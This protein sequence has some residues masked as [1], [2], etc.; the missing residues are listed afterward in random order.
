MDTSTTLRD[1]KLIEEYAGKIMLLA[2]DT[3]TVRFRFFDTALMKLKLQSVPGLR[4][5]VCDGEALSYDPLKL[6]TDYKEEPNI[7]VRLY[8][9][10]MLHAIFMHPYDTTRPTRTSG[11][12][13]RIL[14]LRTLSW[15][16]TFPELP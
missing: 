8:L 9:H 6:L 5:Y 15:R 14:R 2:R 7:A 12:S 3:I 1:D 11:T 10:V 4:G 13:P 16:W